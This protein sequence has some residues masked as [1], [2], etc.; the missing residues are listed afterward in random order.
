MIRGT[1]VPLSLKVNGTTL[2]GCTN[3][4]AIIKQ[5]DY[6]LEKTVVAVP[7]TSYCTISMDLTISETLKFNSGI[8]EVQV[9]WIDGNGKKDATAPASVDILRIL[10]EEQ[11]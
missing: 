11:S 8:A 4:R 1:S 7:S 3:I 2:S 6:I 10:K 5:D 9:V